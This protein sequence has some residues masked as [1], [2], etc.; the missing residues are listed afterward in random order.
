MTLSLHLKRADR[1]QRRIKLQSRLLAKT[2]LPQLNSIQRNNRILT[3][4]NQS[5][6]LS[7]AQV[8]KFNITHWRRLCNT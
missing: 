6:R 4:D 1:H 3:M 5:I 8:V 7:I 2:S